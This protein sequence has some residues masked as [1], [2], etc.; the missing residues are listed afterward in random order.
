[1]SENLSE[2]RGSTV[3]DIDTQLRERRRPLSAVVVEA[4]AEAADVDPAELGTPLYEQIDPDALDN[5]FSDRHNGM[6]R[7]SGHVVFELLDFEVTVYSDGQ[8]VVHE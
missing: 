7:C 5:L 1:M 2:R 3:N 8:V 6:P 4:V